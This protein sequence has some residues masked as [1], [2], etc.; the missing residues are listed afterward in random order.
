MK[1]VDFEPCRKT[2]EFADLLVDETLRD[3]GVVEVGYKDGLRYSAWPSR[4]GRPAD[5][6]PGIVLGP[7]TACSW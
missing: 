5:G 7:E 4:S 3:P 1:V 6:R 2:A